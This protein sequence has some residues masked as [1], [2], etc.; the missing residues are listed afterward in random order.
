MIIQ[1]TIP[2]ALKTLVYAAVFLT[3][4]IDMTLGAPLPL[5]STPYRYTVL[6]QELSDA[7]QEFG[8]N[9]NIR[10]NVSAEVK[11]R[12]RG[13]MP[14]LPAGEF[15]DRLTAL[16]D[17][18]WYY[19]GLVLYVSAAKEAQTRML[20]L[21][22][23]RFDAFEATLDALNISDERYLVKPANGIVMVS[24]PPR[25]VALVE[26]TFDG[27]VAEA[28]AKPHATKMP[29]ES[30]LQLFRGSSAMIVRNGRPEGN[31]SSDIPPQGSTVRE[32]E[33]NPR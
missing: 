33:L 10:V 19:D 18:Q 29:P 26:Q 6:D 16:Y 5:P 30:V 15:L 8:D 1:R 11:G 21:P 25:F 13:R 27:V 14:D 22:T 23:R 9:L 17:L 20:A 7:L 32:P 28:E 3:T 4:G 24:G 31:Y 12:I 2:H